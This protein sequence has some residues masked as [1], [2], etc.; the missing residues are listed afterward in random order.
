MGREIKRVAAGFTWPLSQVWEGYTNPFYKKHASKCLACDG[1]G[2]TDAMRRLNDLARLIMLSGGDA[3]GGRCHPYFYADAGLYHSRGLVP[4]KDYLEL[5]LGLSERKGQ[6]CHD[7]CD[8]WSA[9]RKIVA[10]AGLKKSWGTC[11]TCKGEGRVWDSKEGKRKYQRWKPKEPPQGPFY[12]LWETVSEGS[13]ISPAFATPEELATWLSTPGN[14]WSTDSGTTKE[15]WLKFINGPGWA[16]SLIVDHS[17]VRSGVE[18]VT[19]QNP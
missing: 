17:G 8:H 12:Q 2:M 9:I 6:A 5:T 7:A 10:A 18:A 14:G 4:S 13:P 1:S 3:A 19:S 15:Q 16:P 11:P